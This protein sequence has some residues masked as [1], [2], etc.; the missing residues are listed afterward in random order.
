MALPSDMLKLAEHII[1][2]KAADFDPSMLEDHYQAALVEILRKKQA[3][4]PRH[5]DPV[6]PSSEN[7]VSLMDAL[8]RSIESEQP[9]KPAATS[10]PSKRR[11]ARKKR[12]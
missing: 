5:V 7:V 10:V 4:L 12:A 8:R 11:P 3:Q 2:T 1:E 6:K 9:K